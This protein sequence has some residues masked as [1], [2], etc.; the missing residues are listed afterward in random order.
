LFFVSRSITACVQTAYERTKKLLKEKSEELN[1]VANE[2]LEKEIIFQ[3]D[4]ERLIGQRPFDA[5]TNYQKATNGTEEDEENEE[6][7]AQTD[8]IEKLKSEVKSEVEH[9]GRDGSSDRED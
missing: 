8:T 9:E 6:A 3:Q 2:L 7:L 5:L 4:L 1:I